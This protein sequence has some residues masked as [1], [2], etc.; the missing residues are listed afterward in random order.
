MKHPH[1]QK[2]GQKTMSRYTVDQ[3]RQDLLGESKVDP[4]LLVRMDARLEKLEKRTDKLER[5]PVIWAGLHIAPIGVVIS[6][7][8]GGLGVYWLKAKLGL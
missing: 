3:L 4:G 7:I 6:T 5:N 2:D 1:T 8:L